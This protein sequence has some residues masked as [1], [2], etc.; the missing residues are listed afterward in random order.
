MAEQALTTQEWANRAREIAEAAD[1]AMRFADEIPESFLDA[2][3][4]VLSE[5]H[6]R[7]VAELG[8]DKADFF[9]RTLE[10]GILRRKEGLSASPGVETLERAIRENKPELLMS[11]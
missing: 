7:L 9:V 6:Q 3:E 4:S 1:D 11:A 8:M 5:L 2:Y 10:V